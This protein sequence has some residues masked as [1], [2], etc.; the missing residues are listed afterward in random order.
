MHKMFCFVDVTASFLFYY[1][2]LVHIYRKYTMYAYMRKQMLTVASA[3]TVYV[4]R[5]GLCLL[6]W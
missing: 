4:L 2:L 6:E 1:V 5:N 3:C